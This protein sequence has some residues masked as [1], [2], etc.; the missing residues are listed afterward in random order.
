MVYYFAQFFQGKTQTPLMNVSMYLAGIQLCWVIYS[1]MFF[2]VYDFF[3]L[4]NRF[5]RLPGKSDDPD[6]PGKSDVPDRS[7]R[8]RLP[9]LLGILKYH[10]QKALCGG[11]SVFLIAG[12][13]TASGFYPP[14]HIAL[15]PYEISLPAEDTQLKS[16]NA[17]MI[18]DAHIG[19]SIREKE[20]RKIA[21]RINALTPDIVFL[22]GDIFD[23]GTTDALKEQASD[24][25]SGIRAKY[26]V[27]YILG[28]HDDYMGGTLKQVSY[29]DTET[30]T[31]LIDETRLIDDAFYLIGRADNPEKRAS[32][33][34]L[35]QKINRDLPVILLDHRPTSP[36]KEGSALVSLQLSGHTHNGQIYPSQLFNF[37]K[38]SIRYGLR[39]INDTELLVSSGV[40]TYGIPIR[41]ASRSEIVQLKIIFE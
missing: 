17:V 3:R 11:L 20:L 41:I 2:L 16:L 9:N 26:G 25:L 5:V 7:I 40:G 33:P 39:K 21:D 32:L 22:L 35:E 38:N 14:A 12:L 23:E 31:P 8:K 36:N 6:R 37:S 15:T 18:S 1:C 34:A 28:N 19:V 10:A 30:V 24:I 4:V 27:Y 13:I 29:F